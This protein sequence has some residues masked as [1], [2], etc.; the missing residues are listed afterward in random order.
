[1]VSAVLHISGWLFEICAR[2][3]MASCSYFIR[4][5]GGRDGGLERKVLLGSKR[6]PFG[7][8]HIVLQS[9]LIATRKKVDWFLLCWKNV[10]DLYCF[11]LSSDERKQDHRIRGSTLGP[12]SV[13]ILGMGKFLAEIEHKESNWA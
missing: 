11:L 3:V 9:I 1:M 10:Q 6:Q 12:L 4:M 13:K 5:V 8:L 7:W 2:Y